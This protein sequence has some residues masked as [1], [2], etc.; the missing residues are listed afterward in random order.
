VLLPCCVF[1]RYVYKAR[2]DLGHMLGEAVPDATP[3]R[4]TLRVGSITVRYFPTARVAIIFAMTPTEAETVAA[5]CR[6][7]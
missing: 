2:C 5:L 1:L 6:P 3:T 4:Y 7:P